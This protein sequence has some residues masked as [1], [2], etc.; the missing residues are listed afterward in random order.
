MKVRLTTLFPMS[1]SGFLFEPSTSLFISAGLSPRADSSNIAARFAS[2]WSSDKLTSPST[3]TA[4]GGAGSGGRES[5]CSTTTA[6][7][8]LE[9]F[10]GLHPHDAEHMP[11]AARHWH[12]IVLHEELLL[13][14]QHS[15]KGTF[16]FSPVLPSSVGDVF[17]ISE[18][19]K[20]ALEFL[21]AVCFLR[22]PHSSWKSS[23]C[24][25]SSELSELSESDVSMSSSNSSRSPLVL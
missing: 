16:G 21:L 12:F 13:Q 17:W 20:S 4:T 7:S 24:N 15:P 2:S 9:H 6:V 10:F 5:D 18:S 11:S 23:E 3:K 8:R 25:Q 22:L 1:D 14:V 19:V